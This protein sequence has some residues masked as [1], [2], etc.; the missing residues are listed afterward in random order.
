MKFKKDDIGSAVFVGSILLGLGLDLLFGRP[1]VG[2]LLGVGFIL[3]ELSK[4]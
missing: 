4:K 3:V 2:V 1:D